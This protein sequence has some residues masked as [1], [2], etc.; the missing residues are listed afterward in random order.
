M[1]MNLYELIKDRKTY[2]PRDKVKYYMYQ[3]FKSIEHMHKKGIF[4][5]DIKP[6]N[7]LISGELVKL[8]DLGSC[9]GT[10]GEHPYTE[11]ISTR[12]YRS[13]ECLMTDGYY[14]QKMDIWGAGCVMFE[15]LTLVPLFPGKNELDMIHRIHNILGT[16]S[17]NVL[18][19]FQSHASHMEFNFPQKVGTGIDKLL[20]HVTPD[21]LDLLKQMLIYDPEK[22]I[23]AEQI[24]HHE[25]FRDLLI[26]DRQKE[27]QTTL[28]S[29]RM[30]PGFQQYQNNNSNDFDK[31]SSS[32]QYQEKFNQNK[33]A[34]KKKKSKKQRD[35]APSYEL[36]RY[37]PQVKVIAQDLIDN[38]LPLDE[39]PYV[40]EDPNALDAPTAKDDVKSLRKDKAQ[41]KWA[42]KDKRK[43]EKPSS[44]GS[45]V[46]IFVLGGMTYSEIRSVYEVSAKSHREVIIGSNWPVTP[47]EIVQNLRELKKSEKLEQ[48]NL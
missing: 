9:R 38:A 19:R 1:E 5:R 37:V 32:T 44:S 13:P 15:I 31:S 11:Y 41:P 46:I 33:A 39:F 43:S 42:N 29:A 17:Q 34:D 36:S 20:P 6:E 10:F 45:K 14:D 35:D 40:K 8:A 24:L 3:L 22:R 7:I 25:Y 16:P 30:S 47:K 21:C 28:N 48:D 23:T 4:H 18:D 2:L 26:A 27:F 12:W